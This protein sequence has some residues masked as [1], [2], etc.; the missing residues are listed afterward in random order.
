MERKKM[1]RKRP[2]KEK[3]KVQKENRRRKGRKMQWNWRNMIL[4]YICEHLTSSTFQVFC[5]IYNMKVLYVCWN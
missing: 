5:I 1:R 3:E 4:N 2:R